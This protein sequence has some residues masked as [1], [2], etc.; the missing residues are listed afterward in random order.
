MHFVGFKNT[1]CKKMHNM[2]NIKFTSGL[3]VYIPKDVNVSSRVYQ[4]VSVIS[5]CLSL[6]FTWYYLNCT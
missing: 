5:I 6:S 3:F 2:N 4:Y 1:E